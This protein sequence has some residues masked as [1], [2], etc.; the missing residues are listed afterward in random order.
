V[1]EGQPSDAGDVDPH[2]LKKV[3][4]NA[5]EIF[6]F[7]PKSL[8]EAF[9]G[10]V[11][12]ID[13]STLL[14]P[15]G[16]GKPGLDEIEIRYRK[17]IDAKR[18]VVPAHVAREF[19]RQRA[20][21]IKNLFSALSEAREKSKVSATDYPVLMQMVE[22]SE[23]AA[24]D[25]EIA[26]SFAKR[27]DAL[28]QLLKRIQAWRWDDPVSELYRRL[29]DNTVVLE[30][31]KDDDAAREDAKWRLES[32]VPPGYAD[33]AK[34]TNAAGDVLVWHTILTVGRTRQKNDVVLVSGDV[35]NDWFYRSKGIPLYPR[36]ELTDEYRRESTG[37]SFHIVTLA[38]FLRR[39]EAPPAVVK[40]VEAQEVLSQSRRAKN[41]WGFTA[42]RAVYRWLVKNGYGVDR[43]HASFSDFMAHRNGQRIAIEVK[44]VT[45]RPLWRDKLMAVVKRSGAWPDHDSML[46][47]FVALRR[48][49]AERAAGDLAK[50][51]WSD[52]RERRLEV[53]VGFI[54]D[55]GDLELL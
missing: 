44:L 25:K 20:E 19:A 1:K 12:V 43:K 7:R 6:Q 33:A 42:E 26:A 2:I 31:D 55:D 22:Y 8:D 4:P 46:V 38:D 35:K 51:D 40:E 29:F 34:H 39:L 24:T 54:G 14:V 13:T 32:R 48:E 47:F 41:H 21:Q 3:F 11:F 23:L 36:F 18:L 37:G 50:V 15:Y 28:E 9:A 52:A 49:H 27:Q 10:A 45:S 30:S 17:L 5:H 16:V 53:Q